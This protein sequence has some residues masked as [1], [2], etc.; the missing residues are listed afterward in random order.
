MCFFSV[1][2]RGG[3]TE[4][5]INFPGAQAVSE[6]FLAEVADSKSIADAAIYTNNIERYVGQFGYFEAAC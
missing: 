6:S 3:S 1:S 5:K 4:Q 2:Q